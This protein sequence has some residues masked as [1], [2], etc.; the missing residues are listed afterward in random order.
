MLWSAVDYV[1]VANTI[2]LDNR[3]TFDM[4]SHH[5]PIRAEIVEPRFDGNVDHHA[6]LI[7][8]A[9]APSDLCRTTT[10]GGHFGASIAHRDQFFATSKGIALSDW[11]NQE[12]QQEKGD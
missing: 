6:G 11:G 7:L 10:F 5:E 3:T 8:L 4:H 2:D 1:T 9:V 12:E